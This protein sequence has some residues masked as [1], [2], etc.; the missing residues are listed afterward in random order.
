MFLAS[1]HQHFRQA[2]ACH[3]RAPQSRLPQQYLTGLCPLRHARTLAR[4]RTR[5]TRQRLY[6]ENQQLR[7]ALAERGSEI[8]LDP[9]APQQPERGGSHRQRGGGLELERDAPFTGVDRQW[10]DPRDWGPVGRLEQ[11]GG[12]GGSANS[13][14][15]LGA[16]SG[17]G[18]AARN[19]LAL[20]YEDV[21]QDGV[22]PSSL[23]SSRQGVGA[24]IPGAGAAVDQGLCMLMCACVGGKGVVHTVAVLWMPSSCPH[25]L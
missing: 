16:N 4:T 6:L 1:I 18:I 5:A 25:S 13:G 15:N 7:A 19:E 14:A 24:G 9:E 3:S 12:S 20:P 10:E 17:S 2:E 11:G 23:L 22:P 21:L 8:A